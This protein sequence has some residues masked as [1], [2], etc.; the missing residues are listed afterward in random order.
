MLLILFSFIILNSVLNSNELT[1][2]EKSES[3]IEIPPINVIECVYFKEEKN[4][5]QI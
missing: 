1:D 2:I 5:N 3:Q 4:S